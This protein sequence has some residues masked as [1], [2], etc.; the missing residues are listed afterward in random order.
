MP[1]HLPIKNAKQVV[2]NLPKNGKNPYNLPQ[3]K[4]CKYSD[5]MRSYF[6]IW[7]GIIFLARGWTQ[8]GT[9]WLCWKNGEATLPEF[10]WWKEHKVCYLILSERYCN[11]GFKTRS[12]S[13]IFAWHQCFLCLWKS[14]LQLW[15]NQQYLTIIHLNID[16][17]DAIVTAIWNLAFCYSSLSRAS[18]D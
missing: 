4:S 15:S 16:D 3:N 9:S 11:R 6:C 8:V 18:L 5:I 17:C 10:H 2:D 7:T 14:K 12:T 1:E 13:T